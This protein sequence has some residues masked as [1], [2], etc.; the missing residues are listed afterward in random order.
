VASANR[1]SPRAAEWM[2]CVRPRTTF[3]LLSAAQDQQARL[4]EGIR[5]AGGSAPCAKGSCP[6]GD[7]NPRASDL[8]LFV[9]A[10][11]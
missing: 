4:S 10:Q 5:E 6:R 3:V 2:I 11:A 9:L 1:L 8:W 7:L